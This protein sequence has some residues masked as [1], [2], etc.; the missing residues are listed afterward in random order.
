MRRFKRKTR[1]FLLKFFY[2]KL[3]VRIAT[4]MVLMV[5]IPTVLLGVLL[6]NTSQEAVRNSVLNGHKQI[7]IRAAQEI[8]L[9]VKTP[10]DIL[11]STAAI[12]GI[13]YPVP[14]KQETILV[15]LVLNQPIFIRASSLDLSG[16]ELA[17][18]ELGRRERWDYPK[19]AFEYAMRR[20]NYISKVKILDNHTPFVT[21]AVPIKKQGKIVGTLIADVNLRGIWEMVDN[22]KIAET[23][24][25]F[26][27]SNDGTL[28]AHEDKRKVLKNENLKGQKE[29]AAVLAG[30]TEAIEL[31]VPLEGKLIS[32]YAPIRGLDGGIVLRQKQDEAYLFSKVMK[33]QS[34][35][36]I[37]LSE[38]AAIAA[39][40]FMGK[41]FAAPIRTLAFRIKRV[42]N[43][44]LEH[45]IRIK[46]RDDIGEL[47]RCFN[48]MTKKLK[49]AKER[50]R[51]SAIGE[52][53]AWITHEL[54]NS[55]VSI[56]SFVQLFPER[57]ND[58]KF[59]DRFGRLIPPEINRLERIFR[60][61]SDFSSHS[62]LMITKI[63]PKEIID[64]TL[65]IM[66]E[67]FIKRKITLIYNPQN[68][69]FHSE[70]DPERLKQVFMNLII[71]SM[72]A[73]PEGG[74][75]AV[76]VD[77]LSKETLNSPTHI[78][79]RV[80]DTGKGISREMCEKMFEPFHA[81][82]NGGMGLG[83]TISRKIIE[84]HKG[85]IRVESELGKGTTFIVELPLT[86]K[87][88]PGYEHKGFFG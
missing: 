13:I 6:I 30:R 19:E 49:R 45:K 7:V 46:M 12:L 40:I 10:Q 28:I 84:Q 63:N 64:N 50:E 51:L 29:V 23:G 69:N 34:W 22:I 68:V 75:L 18:S 67:E 5:T 76:S 11:T 81:T 87:R 80:K 59:V 74:S 33:M 38:L 9:F 35:I 82:K 88:V 61:L 70:A 14:W 39:S 1:R 32:S 27:V 77:L 52:A 37:I 79:V 85:D 73:M 15:E 62:E 2:R 54:K 78:E 48:E 4:I 31:N 66:K 58:E 25:A 57:H 72:N 24:R 16:E 56:K 71:N 86:F 36:I 41:A 42:A 55:L 65:E 53:V 83:L 21:M 20:K 17:S 60:E 43:G 3:W 44:D 26:L 47:T 8:E